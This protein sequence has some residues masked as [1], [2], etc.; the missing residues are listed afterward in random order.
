MYETEDIVL[1]GT[2]SCYDGAMERWGLSYEELANL[3]PKLVM[4][5]T[6]RFGKDGSYSNRRGFG[7]VAEW[8]SG[9]TSINGEKTG[10]PILPGIPLADG[11]SGVFGALAVMIKHIH[12]QTHT[13]LLYRPQVFPVDFYHVLW[14]L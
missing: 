7:T 1:L 8:M 2:V 11:V 5:R 13:W 10:P 6:S 9:F 14:L 4:L 3:N 12:G